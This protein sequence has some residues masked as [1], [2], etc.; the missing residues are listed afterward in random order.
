MKYLN[1]RQNYMWLWQAFNPHSSKRCLSKLVK[2]LSSQRQYMSD[3]IFFLV[4]LQ[5]SFFI[6]QIECFVNPLYSKTRL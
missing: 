3:V 1:S 6:S 5:I 2:Y 4:D